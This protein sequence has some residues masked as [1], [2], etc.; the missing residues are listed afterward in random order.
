MNVPIFRV[1]LIEDSPVDAR[2]IEIVLSDAK[3]ADF[4]IV[5]AERLS[6][7]METL[8]QGVFDLVL[9]D[10][11]LPD[12][13]GMETFEQ[14]YERASH[15]PIVILS[16]IN[17]EELAIRAVQK[18]A[19]DYLVKSADNEQVL[20]RALQYAI[21]RFRASETLRQ[22]EEHLRLLTE[23]LPCVFWTTDNNLVFTS[24]SG[25]DELGLNL[26]PQLVVGRSLYQYFATDDPELTVIAAHRKAAG[27]NSQ[28]FDM[29][30]RERHYHVHVEPFHEKNGRVVGTIGV[31]LDVTDQMQA[32]IA[33]EVTRQVQQGLLPKKSPESAVF[34][35]AGASYPADE[36]GG[37]FFTYIPWP[38]GALGVA[39]CDVGGHGLGP[40]MLMAQTRAYLRAMAQTTDDLGR[41]LTLVNRFLC[42]DG[43]EQRL[44]S[45]FFGKFI[46][47]DRV[48]HYAGA[49][50]LAHLL[51][52]DGTHYLLKPAEIPLNIDDDARFAEYVV[53]LEE[54]DI[55]VLYTDGIVECA[56]E[57][58]EQYGTD[59]MLNTVRSVSDLPACEIRD[60][61]FR[62]VRG[63]S[64]IP[65]QQDD[66]TAVV[67]KVRGIE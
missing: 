44:V 66:M 42:S 61:L 57:D 21:E 22:R 51:R 47:T 52:T 56:K 40:A 12:S 45:L 46:A 25:A 37:D 62:E 8:A 64:S 5:R 34:D 6:K 4:E 36:A 26:L 11:S 2:L 29:R 17:D 7:G 10:L 27:G 14:L 67:V 48:L 59:R 24:S 15:V 65:G 1:L 60:H 39:V 53:A 30:W 41:I 3:N 38:D 43:G 20:A 54:G 18:G 58:G 28:T 19:Q 33:L 13:L 16:G 49:G 63:F 55:V 31:A 9:L 35:I 32:K 23:Q 50:H